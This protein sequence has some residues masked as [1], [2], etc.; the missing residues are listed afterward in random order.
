M[1]LE[2]DNGGPLTG[3]PG[4]ALF[5]SN[6]CDFMCFNTGERALALGAQLLVYLSQLDADPMP[7]IIIADMRLGVD[8]AFVGD[9]I[10]IINTVEV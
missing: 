2:C 10:S 1:K 7:E 6:L 8:W 5:L 9:R 3:D 4:I